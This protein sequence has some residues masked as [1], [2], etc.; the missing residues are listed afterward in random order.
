MNATFDYFSTIYKNF[1]IAM[2]LQVQDPLFNTDTTTE[3]TMAT[4]NIQS[5]YEI[6]TSLQ[7]MATA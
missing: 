7:T 2:S 3:F 1:T 5:L 6:L 4:D